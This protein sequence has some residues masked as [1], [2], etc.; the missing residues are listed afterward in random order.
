MF[1]VSLVLRSSVR[2]T[3]F[4]FANVSILFEFFVFFGI[5]LESKLSSS[6]YKM[7]VCVRRGIIIMSLH[8]RNTAPRRREP[9]ENNEL[10]CNCA[11]L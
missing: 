3:D 11:L 1:A 4:A 10:N 5:G 6:Y 7:E 8:T 9:F 2:R